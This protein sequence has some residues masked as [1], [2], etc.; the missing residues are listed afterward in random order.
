MIW[1]RGAFSRNIGGV[2]PL[3]TWVQ[4]SSGDMAVQRAE[5]PSVCGERSSAHE[6]QSPPSPVSLD[7]SSS[8]LAL[9]LARNEW[10]RITVFGTS[11]V[12]SG[13]RLDRQLET[14]SAVPNAVGRRRRLRKKRSLPASAGCRLSG[15]SWESPG[16]EA[17][18][19]GSGFSALPAGL[20]RGS[21]ASGEAGRMAMV[22]GRPKGPQSRVLPFLA[23]LLL[24]AQ[25][26]CHSARDRRLPVRSLD[27]C[28]RP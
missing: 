1:C 17:A 20:L 8:A 15:D 7:L 13:L 23:D 28:R 21:S 9:Q 26:L 6:K 18:D 14:S 27:W 10:A 12:Q 11:R 2:T 19:P 24:V 4:G 5:T 22:T 25:L 3:S 16:P